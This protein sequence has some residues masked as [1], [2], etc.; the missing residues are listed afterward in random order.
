LM[1]IN[2][3]LFSRSA[4][5]FSLRQPALIRTGVSHLQHLQPRIQDLATDTCRR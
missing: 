5:S 3:R 1:A 4:P 2:Y